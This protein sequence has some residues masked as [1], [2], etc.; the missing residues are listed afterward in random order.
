MGIGCLQPRGVVGNFRVPDR[1]IHRERPIHT[2]F[3]TAAVVVEIESTDEETWQK[4]AFY[5]EHGVDEL[6]I[7]SPYARTVIW[8][9]LDEGRYE[10]I[11]H[12]RLLGSG[13]AELWDLIE[14][15]EI[16]D[17]AR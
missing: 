8:L 13:S 4:L 2:W 5:A 9:G 1:G 15:P 11:P 14:W 7:V 6:L 10:P 16:P 17:G 3:A 12:S